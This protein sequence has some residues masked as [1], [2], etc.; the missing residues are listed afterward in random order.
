VLFSTRLY[1]FVDV[2]LYVCRLI[3]SIHFEV[4]DLE[5]L[6]LVRRYIFPKYNCGLSQILHA[7]WYWFDVADWVRYRL[8]I[9]VH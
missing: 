4:P 3:I 8:G 6:L 9:S 1:V 5:S 7:D 2:Y